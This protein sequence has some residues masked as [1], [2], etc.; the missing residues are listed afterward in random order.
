MLSTSGTGMLPG[1]GRP[2]IFGS[3]TPAG[4]RRLFDVAQ[5][6]RDLVARQIGRGSDSSRHTK[7]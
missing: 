5:A 1:A 4:A 3:L 2:A 7:T 6:L